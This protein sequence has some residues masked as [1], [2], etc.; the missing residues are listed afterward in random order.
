MTINLLLFLLK[1]NEYDTFDLSQSDPESTCTFYI[2][3]YD[4][5]TLMFYSQNTQCS[6]EP[7]QVQLYNLEQAYLKWSSNH[8]FFLFKRQ[9]PTAVFPD[10]LGSIKSIKCSKINCGHSQSPT[11]ANE[12]LQLREY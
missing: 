3:Q 9:L 12:L 11:I 5:E 2:N 1:L 4:Q 8:I 7:L 6:P 10:L